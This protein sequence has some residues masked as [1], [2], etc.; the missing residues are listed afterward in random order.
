MDSALSIL[1]IA[2]YDLC[3][4]FFTS[5]LAHGKA[6]SSALGIPWA[7]DNSDN[8]NVRSHIKE[9]FQSLLE[10]NEFENF[11]NRVFP[12]NTVFSSIP[13]QVIS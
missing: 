13:H 6:A 3:G 7:L 8:V 5:V 2:L 9:K 11:F 4:I 12:S 1:T 10:F